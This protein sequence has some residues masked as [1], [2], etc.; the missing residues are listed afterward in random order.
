MARKSQMAT[1]HD[2]APVD[3]YRGE[4]V[5]GGRTHFLRNS[6]LDESEGG[7]CTADLERLRDKDGLYRCW[8]PEDVLDYVQPEEGEAEEDDQYQLACEVV[9]LCGS[10]AL[11]V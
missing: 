1:V 2:A 6:D 5:K 4:G 11:T 9:G 10:L 3:I 7:G 8:H